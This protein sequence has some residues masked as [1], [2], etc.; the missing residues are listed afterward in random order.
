MARSFLVNSLEDGGRFE[1]AVAESR[2][3]A[4]QLGHGSYKAEARGRAYREAGSAGYWTEALR[5]RQAGGIWAQG[6]IWTRRLYMP[7]LGT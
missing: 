1:E 3:E 6:L 5:Q 4:V 7:D 2:V